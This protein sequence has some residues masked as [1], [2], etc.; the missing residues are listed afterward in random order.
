MRP[1]A[2][3][4]GGGKLTGFIIRRLLWIIPVLIV[5]SAIT[6]LLM[7][8]TPGG[9]W[10]R[11]K[12]LP[13]ATVEALNRAYHLDWPLWR[14]YVTYLWNALHAD[15]GPSFKYIGRNVTEI[16]GQGLPVTAQLGLMA[17]V[18]ALLAGIPLGIIA[19][20]RQNT[21]SDY[22]CMFFSIVGIS[23]P[24]FILGIFL[25]VVFASTL[26]WVPTTGW[27]DWHY[28]ILPTVA[29]A[30][31][32]AAQIARFT[33][34]S[35]LEVI[36]QDYVRTARAKGLAEQV[37]ITRHMIKNALIPVVTVLGPITAFLVTGSFVIE[38]LFS[39][40][41]T[42]RL[43][44]QAIGQRDYAMIMGTTLFYALVVAF[45]NILVDV[46]YSFI[47]PRIRCR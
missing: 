24:S 32:P 1:E 38:Y 12:A 29:L 39:I 11:E 37:V 3:A 21:L 10:D 14:Q 13:K 27:K 33:R 34:A 8:L 25:I 2:L 17:L 31:Y 7:H 19:A 26:H 28:W 16:I 15:L 4:A 45:T 44:V 36:R 23:V 30:T 35:M 43:F 5:V 41:G 40:P 18:L 46:L 9:P 47:D 6:F 22:L 42:G 20:I